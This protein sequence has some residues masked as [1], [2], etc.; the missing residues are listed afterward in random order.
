MSGLLF[1]F[2]MEAVFRNLKTWLDKL[3]LKRSGQ[4]HG[5]V[6]DRPEDRLTNLRFADDVLLFASNR[7]DSAKMIADLNTES[8][9]F[10]LKLHLGKTR[11]L[12]SSK[13]TLPTGISCRGLQV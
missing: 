8:A 4:Y 2:V 9:K 6:I 12:T 3:N 5:I 1:N 13:R 10:G 7:A 11:F